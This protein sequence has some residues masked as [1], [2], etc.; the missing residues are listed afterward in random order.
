MMVRHATMGDISRIAEIIVFGKRMAYRAIFQNDYFSFNELQ[1]MPIADEFR[2]KPELINNFL[3]Y[4]DGIVRGVIN[5]VNREDETEICEF[6]VE[7]VFKRSG[8]GSV[9]MS[10]L[11]EEAKAE[12][13]KRIFLWVIKENVPA[14]SFYEKNG[15]V[16]TGEE[17]LIEGT[18]KLDMCYE[19][20]L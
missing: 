3:V 20:I 5:R 19:R 12:G 15:F 11:V 8:I 4:D 1:V 7:P 13:K 18:D 10:A 16:P 9:L 14:R 2:A 17:Q 6:Y